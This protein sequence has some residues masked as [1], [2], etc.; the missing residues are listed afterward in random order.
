MSGLER[1]VHNCLAAKPDVQDAYIAA[2]AALM[3]I[4][5]ECDQIRTDSTAYTANERAIAEQI[6]RVVARSLCLAA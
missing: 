5:D 1:K 3:A 4:L 2:R 6:Q